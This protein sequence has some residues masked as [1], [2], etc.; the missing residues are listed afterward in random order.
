MKKTE[1]PKVVFGKNDK[2]GKIK[3]V[4][5][6]RRNGLEIREV[7]YVI[8][9]KFNLLS[10]SQFYDKGNNVEFIKLVCKIRNVENTMLC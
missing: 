6:I 8:A 7:F 9:L 10:S 3:G 1:V 5:I 4:G 2:P